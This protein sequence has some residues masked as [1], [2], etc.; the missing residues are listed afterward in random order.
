[1]SPAIVVALTLGVPAYADAPHAGMIAAVNADCAMCHALPDV[2][3]PPR[4]AN[5]VSCHQWVRAVSANPAARAKALTFFPKWERYERNVKTYFAV[6]DLSVGFARL[7][8]AWI[9]TY[10]RDPYDLRPAMPETMVRVGLSSERI[11]AIAAWAGTFTVV[12]PAT[13][14]PAAANVAEGESIFR[15][16]GCEACHTFGERALGPGVPS[17][18]DLRHARDRMGDDM[19]VAWIE[20]PASIA[21]LT[22]MPAMGLTHAQAIA[23]RD[24]LVLAEPGGKQP[25]APATVVASSAPVGWDDVESRVFGKI[26]IHCHMDPVQNEGRA[27]PGNAG[28]FGWAA[29]GLELQNYES[30]RDH[31]ASILSALERRRHEAARDFVGPGEVPVAMV[32]PE[33]PGMPLGLPPI[34]DEDIALIK[35]WYAR[36][37]P[38]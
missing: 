14:T 4:T 29:T 8:P 37:A 23:V 7:D 18:P 5:C 32:V 13:P 25:P 16:R 24:Y 36:G 22:T 35:G 34:S 30:V 11:D 28:G 15:Q 1:M 10:L 33:K 17:A 6:P 31:E 2:A 9:R 19:L 20:N 3:P 27:G 38:R 26:C 21:P 12:V